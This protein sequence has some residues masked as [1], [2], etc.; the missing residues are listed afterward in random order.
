MLEQVSA[1]GYASDLLRDETELL[2]SRDAG[3]AHQIVFGV[4]RVQNQLDYLIEKYSGRKVNDLDLA[5]QLALRTAI[6][7]LRYLE[8]IPPHAA[9]DDAV[10]FVKHKKRAASGLV[11][12]VLRKIKREAETWPNESLRLACPDWLLERWSTHFG[13]EAAT[14]IAE[15]ALKEPEVFTRIASDE[16][17]LIQDIG[18]QSIVPM[19][20]LNSEHRF[21]DLCAA[22]GNKTSQALERRPRFAVACDISERRLQSV[23]LPVAKV[24]LDA[25]EQ[26]PFDAEFDRILIDAP[27]SGTGT[28]ARNPEIKWRLS[29][30]EL[31]R[32]HARQVN[33]AKRAAR[34][35]AAGGKLLYATCSL[36]QEENE[37]VISD[38]TAAAGLHCESQTYRLPGRD[39]GDGFFAA[40]LVKPC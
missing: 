4:L 33:I 40:V 28:L 16:S 7:Q 29:E 3:L 26:L 35:L 13:A 30:N 12:A 21:L 24:V 38:I 1:G 11:N 39:P 22:P 31:I 17:V 19:L 5:V 14:A 23:S 9:V 34:I 8:R 15:A 36:E 2:S 18:S 27:C 6:Y 20:D 37:D 10:E 25:T 32:H